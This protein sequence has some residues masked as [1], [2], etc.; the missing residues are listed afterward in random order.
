VLVL[1]SLPGVASLTA[2]QYYAH[3][4]NQFWRILGDIVG[5]QLS[6]LCYA[7]RLDAMLEAGVG[8]WD[9]VASAQRK[10]SLDVAMREI[11]YNDLRLHVAALPS[12]RAIAFNGTASGRARRLLADTT[13]A[14]LQ[15]PSTSPAMTLR[16]ADKLTAWLEI[17]QYLSIR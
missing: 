8:L 12:L 9:V 2:G 4:R 5:V 13:H 17:R 3:P 11:I 6:A 16:Y 1:G 10:G 7:E 15:L 14:L